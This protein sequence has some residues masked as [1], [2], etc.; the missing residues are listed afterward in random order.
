MSIIIIQVID[1]PRIFAHVAS[2]VKNTALVLSL[3]VQQI[4]YTISHAKFAGIIYCVFI[5]ILCLAGVGRFFAGEGDCDFFWVT[6]LNVLHQDVMN[7]LKCR[8]YL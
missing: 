4:V 5:M 6:K 3:Q 7:C 1:K 2:V 8:N